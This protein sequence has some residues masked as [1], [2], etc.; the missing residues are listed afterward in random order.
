M[1]VAFYQSYW[2]SCRNLE[3]KKAFQKQA[4]FISGD[5][6]LYNSSSLQLS[7]T[8]GGFTHAAHKCMCQSCKRLG[9]LATFPFR[10]PISCMLIKGNVWRFC[11]HVHLKPPAAAQVCQLSSFWHETLALRL[12]LVWLMLV[13]NLLALS[14]QKDT[15]SKNN[16]RP[17]MHNDCTKC[18]AQ[19][20]SL[21]LSAVYRS[22]PSDFLLKFVNVI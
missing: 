4:K 21:L 3:E 18:W 5:W 14:Q 13:N 22:L 15:Q 19:E 1:P 11:L 17:F 10:V 2:H 6:S 20:F 12:Y 7:T 16:W 8:M 9:L